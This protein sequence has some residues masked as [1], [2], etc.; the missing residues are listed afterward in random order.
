MALTRLS[1]VRPVAITMLFL[2]LAAMGAVAYTR[3]P[4]ERFP[5]I[6]FPSVG[7]SV[8]YPG[9][10]PEDVEA[11][12]TR[13]IEDAVV[14]IG[15]LDSIESTSSEGSSRVQVR[16]AEGVDVNAAAIDIGR[17]VAQVQRQLPTG[18][19]NPSVSKADV[20]AF[21]I[22]NVA[23][24][25]DRLDLE[26]LTTLV[27]DQVQPL[28]QSVNGVA[29]V[30]V[31][32]GVRR[33]VQVRVDPEKLRAYGLSLAQVQSALASQNLALPGGTIRTT[34]QVF[35]TR[36][37]ALA[38][39]ASDL[40][41]IAVVLPSGASAANAGDTPVGPAA[42]GVYLK[43][44]AEILDTHAFQS[45]FQRL[46]GKNAVG[47]V[48]TQQSGVNGIKVADAIH[49]TL[50]Q[51]QASLGQ[52]SGV[53]FEVVNETALFTRAAVDDVQ[54][55]LYL[56]IF[57]TA[58]VLLV[59]LHTLRNTLMVLVAI[60]FSLV[61]TFFVMFLLGFNLDTMSLMALALL[62]GILVDDSIVV[63]ENINRHLAMGKSAWAA[64]LDGRNEIGLAAIAI[65][66]TD[67]VVYAPVAFM[68]GNIG[69]LFREFGLTIVAATL[70]SLLVSFTLTPM[71]ASRLL[72]GEALEHIT[73]RGPWV[74]FTRAW[75]R[76]F[77]R[78]RRGY[79]RLLA[80]ALDVRWLPVLVGFGMLA[81]VVS[82]I[83]L[84][85]VGTEFVPQEDDNQFNVQVQLPVGTSVEVTSAAMKQIEDQLQAL[86]EV[87]T[88]FASVG[89][90]GGG[91]GNAQEQSGSIAVG[92]VD[93]SQR[94]RSVFDMVQQVRTLGARVPEAQVRTGVP[95]PL[96]GG[97]GPP[98]EIRITGPDF[99]RL[100]AITGQVLAIVTRTPGA[101]EARNT[102]IVP[103]P[104]Y[105]AVVDRQK[106]L[107]YGITAQTVANTLNAAVQGVVASELR[108]EGQDQADIVLQLQGAE[109]LTPEQLGAIP[110][111]TPGG[112]LVR[113][114]QVA[115][116]VPSSS[117]GQIARFNRARGIEVQ[118]SVVG[119]PVGDVLRDVREQTSQLP[120]PVGYAIVLTGQGSQLDTAFGALVQALALS[121]VLMYMLMAALYESFIYPFAVIVCLP[122]ALVGAFLG[123][124]AV[125]D[126]INIFSMIGMI[127]LVGLVAKN[128]ILLVDYTNRLRANGLSRREA[129][130]EAGPTRLRPILMT[131]ITLLCAML[132]L[133]LKIGSGAESRSPM[134]IVVLGGMI[135]STLLTL[136]LVPCAY[137]YL[138]DL[139][140]LV[141]W[142]A[143]P[144]VVARPAIAGGSG[145]EPPADVERGA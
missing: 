128:A 60:P 13:P 31:V 44:V 99:D 42:N 51:L 133:A 117:A 10:A 101:V 132:P 81:L 120:L 111:Q 25:S 119:R 92:L 68:T 28:V 65:T 77:D 100:Q 139:Q 90:G 6:S 129:L 89:G 23:V 7:V 110:I 121:I 26:T 55:N 91:F 38:Q 4:V 140:N 57:L 141:L 123:L 118:A 74:A 102:T 18:T 104:E 52:Q 72:K 49:Q 144:P 2:A 46:N 34:R 135:T 33:Q 17:K 134:A 122:V 9:A 106:A 63:L 16:F 116:L 22:M 138:D 53:R 43:D 142:R 56:A 94:N 11:L 107:D 47:L 45:S 136:V 137:T 5:N 3:L 19:G 145:E 96:V 29:D 36:T 30:S 8:S 20:A 64:A 61:S 73:G 66:L 83:P 86:P 76:W 32:G 78:L 105:R 35:N 75:E 70:F 125:G 41:T 37:E 84:H 114:D 80:R 58:A 87:R 126:T 130:L 27:N 39:Q 98:V 67:V 14:G 71:L 82:F 127:M 131:T 95:A 48:I 113:L 54:R 108:P 50:D 103:S 85:V 143:R 12:V 109:T 115:A 62:V 69:Q 88:V 24:S 1:L 21:P 15:G 93:K 97:G 40:N 124:L 59:F 112:G 79:R